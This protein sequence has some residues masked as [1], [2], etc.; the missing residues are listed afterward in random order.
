[1]IE[2]FGCEFAL[3]QNICAGGL[4]MIT[5]RLLEKTD[6]LLT[7]ELQMINESELNAILTLLHLIGFITVDSFN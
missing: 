7:I 1:M 4:S 6:L 3:K 2:V 5:D